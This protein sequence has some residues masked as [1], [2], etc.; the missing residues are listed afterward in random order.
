MS[1]R[2]P[3]LFTEAQSV[4]FRVWCTVT[5]TSYGRIADIDLLVGAIFAKVI[6][7]QK[8]PLLARTTFIEFCLLSCFL[9]FSHCHVDSSSNSLGVV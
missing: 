6:N 7:E 9:Q 5:S 8:S 1:W 2:N 3:Y 4:R